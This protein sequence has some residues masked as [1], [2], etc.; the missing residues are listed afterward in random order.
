[1]MGPRGITTYNIILYY[2]KTCFYRKIEEHIRERSS[3]TQFGGRGGLLKCYDALRGRE[4]GSTNVLRNIVFDY[5]VLRN[6]LDGGYIITLR[7]VTWGREGQK[8]FRIALR[9]I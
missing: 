5:L 4:G 8:S 3:I 1:M 2:Y 7:H 9:N 6:V